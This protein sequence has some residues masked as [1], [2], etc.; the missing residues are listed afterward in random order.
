MN[1]RSPLFK[2]LF[3]CPGVRR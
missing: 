2:G 3:F 1:S